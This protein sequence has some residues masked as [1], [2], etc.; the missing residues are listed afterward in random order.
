MVCDSSYLHNTEINR[1]MYYTVYSNHHTITF[2]G[3]IVYTFDI[4]GFCRFDVK[5]NFEDLCV[6]MY[7]LQSCQ[8]LRCRRSSPLFS[9]YFKTLL[10][11]EKTPIFSLLKSLER[12]IIKQRL[13]RVTAALQLL[14][15]CSSRKTFNTRSK[16]KCG[17][18]VRYAKSPSQSDSYTASK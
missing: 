4:Q 2:I 3:K 7:I 9:L 13:R 8:P 11:V 12:F 14:H 15:D 10:G 18:F 16:S 17:H 5:M 6:Y 1:Q